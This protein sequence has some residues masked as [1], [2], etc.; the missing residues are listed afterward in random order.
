VAELTADH[1]VRTDLRG[2]DSH[3]VGLLPK[4]HDW[5]RAGHIVPG[6]EPAIVR[7]DGPTGLVDGNQGWGHHVATVAMEQAIAKARAHGVGLVAVRNSNHYG[8]AAGYS[9]MALAHDM[10]GLS[11]TNVARPIVVPTHGRRAMLGTN[12][13]SVAAP[14]GDEP[15]FVLDMA[16]STVAIGKLRVAA[17]LGRR[18]PEGWALSAS[19][20][21]TT[22][23]AVAFA[24]RLLTPLGGTPE[25]GSHKGYGLALMVDILAG[26]LAGAVHSDT[27]ERRPAAT[28][29]ADVGHLLGAVDIG[30][31][32]PLAEFKADM[33]DLVRSLKTSPLA[34]G[35]TRIWVAGEPERECEARRRRDG[36]PLPGPL[37]DELAALA[38]GL[39]IP[40]TLAREPA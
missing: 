11:L 26:V 4:Y 15:P 21:P 30:R 28:P 40:F 8:A 37:L 20:V 24:A 5:V 14:A 16:T 34:D 27:G 2:V 23:P 18:I 29:R 6:A 13:I 33:D 39:G 1:I 25:A 31:F 19:G 32:R 38:A 36:I 7:D 17:R 3:G 12:P 10:I 35:A 22:D 9:M